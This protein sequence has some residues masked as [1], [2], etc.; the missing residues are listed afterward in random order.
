MDQIWFYR[1]KKCMDHLP[2]KRK[3]KEVHVSISVD[4]HS[5]LKSM[6]HAMISH[7][8]AWDDSDSALLAT[9]LAIISLEANNFIL[10]GDW[11]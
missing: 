7:K 8:Q 4:V 2:K 9:K 1:T 3:R 5:V 11:H 6:R 10:E